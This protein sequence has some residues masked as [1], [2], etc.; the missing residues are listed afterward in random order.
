MRVFLFA[1]GEE[2]CFIL[3]YE[4][5]SLRKSK[6]VPFDICLCNV[7]WCTGFVLL[8]LE[9]ELYRRQKNSSRRESP[10][11]P[12]IPFEFLSGITVLSMASKVSMAHTC[13][14]GMRSKTIFR[15]PSLRP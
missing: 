2:D 8:R 6:D 12:D 14:A 15:I 7:A 3:T 13:H 5:Q 4:L 11:K 1:A 9:K 10:Q